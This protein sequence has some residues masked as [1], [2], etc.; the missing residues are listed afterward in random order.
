MK[1]LSHEK[2]RTN[3]L[4]QRLD[5]VLRRLLPP[6][7]QAGAGVG[8]GRGGL[9]QRVE[10]GAPPPARGRCVTRRSTRVPEPTQF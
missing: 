2:W 4:L 6:R 10:V 9:V 1:T 5:L 8:L 3:L 7:V